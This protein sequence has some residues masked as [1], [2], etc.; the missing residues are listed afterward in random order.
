MNKKSLAFLSGALLLASF[1]P[2]LAFAS[3][4]AVVDGGTG[5]DASTT[6]NGAIAFYDSAKGVILPQFTSWSLS[7]FGQNLCGNGCSSFARFQINQDPSG[8]YTN[9]ITKFGPFTSFMVDGNGR[10]GIGGASTAA[11]LVVTTTGTN[12]TSTL[13]VGKPGQN[14][15]TCLTVYRTD[16]SALYEYFP[17]GSLAPVYTATKPSGCEN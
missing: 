13:V 2:A 8:A 11:D 3:P 4:L 15:G 9:I 6:P 12:A 7:S 17:A 16:G 14:K 1:S 5:T 10:V